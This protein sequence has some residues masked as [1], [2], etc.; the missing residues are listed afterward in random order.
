[1]LPSRAH[2]AVILGMGVL[3]LGTVQ[4]WAAATRVNLEFIEASFFGD[5]MAGTVVLRESSTGDPIPGQAVFAKLDSGNR[6]ATEWMPF[7]TDEQG[8][9]HITIG[10]LYRKD[11]TA[12]ET[13]KFFAEFN[14]RRSGGLTVVD[15]SFTS[16]HVD[17]TIPSSSGA[18]PRAE[19]AGPMIGGVTVPPDEIC[20][21]RELRFVSL[22]YAAD[23]PVPEPNA[24][25][26]DWYWTLSD[27]TGAK[28]RGNGPAIF[29]RTTVAGIHE[30]QLVVWDLHGR[31]GSTTRTFVVGEGSF[32]TQ[33]FVREF[34][35]CPAIATGPGPSKKF[36]TEFANG[37]VEV[38]C[39]QGNP[40]TQCYD[41][42]VRWHESDGTQKV[43][44]L[45]TFPLG[46][47]SL[48]IQADTCT[49]R[50]IH[51]RWLNAEGHYRDR[52]R[53]AHDA[54]GNG[55]YDGNSYHYFPETGQFRLDRLYKVFRTTWTDCAGHPVPHPVPWKEIGA[56]RY[57][58]QQ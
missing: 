8:Q 58:A 56:W 53:C 38:Q 30:L 31:V 37:H 18:S 24:G 47:N 28:T 14:I 3:I 42:V 27:P 15:P 36:G 43:I 57:R 19:V 21:G 41:F 55:V 32:I 11:G 34:G 51:V 17:R 12:Y 48:I 44:G 23:A 52:T 45:C 50:I 10:R 1:M 35:A 54:N 16:A 9:A 2:L 26:D 4:G 6:D 39:V 5:I 20:L 7:A 25:I 22:S 46:Q 13:S 40:A 49:R 33:E 29:F